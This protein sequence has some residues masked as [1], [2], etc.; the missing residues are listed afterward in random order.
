[1][2]PAARLLAAVVRILLREWELSYLPVITFFTGR[3]GPI[4]QAT[5]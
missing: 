1:M 5:S 4:S 3:Y 2:A